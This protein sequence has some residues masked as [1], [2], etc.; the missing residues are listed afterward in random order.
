MTTI[1]IIISVLTVSVL[2]LL[3]I[4]VGRSSQKSSD[5]Q[6]RNRA[7]IEAIKKRGLAE[8]KQLLKQGANP[9]TREIITT[10]PDA[11]ENAPGGQPKP[12]DTALMIAARIG[13]IEIVSTL[14]QHGAK[15]DNRGDYGG[16]ALMEAVRYDQEKIVKL[17][18][19][20]GAKPNLRTGN[21][22]TAIDFA[23]N[24]GR[25]EIVALLLAKGADINGGAGETPLIQAVS[26]D[27]KEM[28]ILLLKKRANVNFTR[29]NFTPLEIALL[30]E[31]EEITALLRK[32]GGKARSLEELQRPTDTMAEDFAA[33]RKEQAAKWKH[34]QKLTEDDRAVVETAL[35]DIRAYQGKDLW[36]KQGTEIVLYKHTAPGPG[37]IS[38]SQLNSEL[39]DTQAND[40]SLKIREQLLR[41]NWESISLETLKFSDSHIVLAEPKP[42]PFGENFSKQFPKAKGWVQIY[43]PGFSEKRDKAV[44]RLRFGPSPHGASATYFLIK[45]D[46]KWQVKW[47]D[48]AYYA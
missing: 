13:N 1:R 39:D 18:L 6:P 26:R 31:N 8:V 41:R 48:F 38:D 20:K 4:Q 46:G 33:Y 5:I 42:D 17:L 36:L 15:I 19:D 28:V 27:N 25:T 40:V 30:N 29:E 47:R 11:S 34:E 35:T 45:K 14:L 23:A 43:L 21:G 16:T 9:N 3:Y 22:N 24:R 7:L 2:L 12:A 10:K 37:M 32:A 44:L